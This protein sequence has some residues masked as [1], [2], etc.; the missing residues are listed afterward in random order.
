MSRISSFLIA[1]VI[2]GASV[3]LASFLVSR[4]P[5]PERVEPPPQSYAQTER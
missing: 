2:I 5:E 4:A 3:A 1:V